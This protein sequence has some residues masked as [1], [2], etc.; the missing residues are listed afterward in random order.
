MRARV[1]GTVLAVGLLALVGCGDD[2]DDDGAA[3][4]TTTAASTTETTT[5]P[6]SAPSTTGSSGAPTTSSAPPTTRGAGGA[7]DPPEPGGGADPGRSELEDGR[8]FGFWRSFEIGDTTAVGD[9]DLASFLTGAEAEAAAAERG[10]EVNNDYYVVN[11]NPRLRTLVAR[12]DTVVRVL[13]GGEPDL[14]ETNVADFA[15]ER[16]EEAGFWVTVED[17]IV[18]EIEQQFVP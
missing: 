11:D 9:F 16:T 15:V 18:T 2:D 12:G 4:T 6:S 14:R 17:G 7:E 1:V 8:H 13:D 5:S 3:A 10:D